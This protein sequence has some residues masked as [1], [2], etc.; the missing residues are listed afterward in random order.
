MTGNEKPGDSIAYKVELRFWGRM[1]TTAFKVID[2]YLLKK[3]K[4]QGQVDGAVLKGW[5]ATS[6]P[7]EVGDFPQRT[8]QEPQTAEESHQ[9]HSRSSRVHLKMVVAEEGKQLE[10][11]CRRRLLWKKMLKTNEEMRRSFG[12][13]SRSSAQAHTHTHNRCLQDLAKKEQTCTSYIG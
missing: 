5:H 9:G 11:L 2:V 3:A 7:I 4:Y 1:I 6:H 13:L 10:P 12:F 8:G